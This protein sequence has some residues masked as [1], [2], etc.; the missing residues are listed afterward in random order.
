MIFWY[1]SISFF[2]L[3]FPSFYLPSLLFYLCDFVSLCLI[4][5]LS[6]RKPLKETVVVPAWPSRAVS[7]RL[8]DLHIHLIELCRSFKIERLLK[9]VGRR[10]IAFPSPPLDYLVL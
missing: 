1:T 8:D 9:I 3:Y 10:V 7:D 5:S 6:S 4:S 2:L